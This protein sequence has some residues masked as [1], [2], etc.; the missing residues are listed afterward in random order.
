MSL[1]K[2]SVQLIGFLGADPELKESS[3]S[4]KYLR[5]RIATSERYKDKSGS[6]QENTTWHPVVMWESLAEKAMT[7]LCKGAPVLIE[8]KLINRS[9]VDAK[10][11][12]QFVYEIR[13]TDF[14][15]IDKAMASS[16]SQKS[17]VA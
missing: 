13:A 15:L 6:W 16:K 2:N 1:L 3:N 9:F 4:V 10:G 8:G 11:E 14:V 12:K 5:L 17:E 7:T